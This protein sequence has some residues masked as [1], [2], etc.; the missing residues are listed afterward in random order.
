MTKG[1]PLKGFRRVPEYED[2]LQ[3]EARLAKKY[4]Y[5]PERY[6]FTPF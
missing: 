1:D 4:L 3:E 2:T 5:L 6:I